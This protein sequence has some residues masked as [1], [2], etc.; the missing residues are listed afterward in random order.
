MYN[1][2]N[3]FYAA[4]P[5]NGNSG[6]RITFGAY[7]FTRNVVATANRAGAQLTFEQP[8]TPRLTLA[9]EW[10]SG[11]QAYGYVNTGAHLQAHAKT[12]P[13]RRLSNRQRQRHQRQSPVP[14]GTRLQLQLSA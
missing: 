6:T 2:G 1:A 13:L 10:Y 8:L 12:H 9:A 4:S 11:N 5:N 14:L 7:D 3:Y